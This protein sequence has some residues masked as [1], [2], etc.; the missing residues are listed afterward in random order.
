[1]ASNRRKLEENVDKTKYTI[2]PRDQ[3]AGR[4]HGIKTGNRS[5][6]IVEQ[7]QY[8]GSTLTNQNSI[9]Q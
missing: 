8:L 9:Q 3:N 5:F 2:M 7:F 4:R 1:V 6:D